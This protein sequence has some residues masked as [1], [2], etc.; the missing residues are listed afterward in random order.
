ML[1]SHS[2]IVSARFQDA[3]LSN[4]F[5]P[6][7]RSNSS[8]LEPNETRTGKKF[9]NYNLREYVKRRARDGFHEMKGSTDAQAVSKGIQ[10]AKE[11]L[12]VIKRQ[13]VVYSLYGRPIK[14]VIVSV[15]S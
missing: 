7:S 13:A 8:N 14:S 10:T 12:E 9:H 3:K 4:E 2:S 15:A 11:S 5:T 1:F 6:L